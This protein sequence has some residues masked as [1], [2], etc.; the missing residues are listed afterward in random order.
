MILSGVSHSIQLTT[1]FALINNF[2]EMI[3]SIRIDFCAKT[4]L[5]LSL[6]LI[7]SHLLN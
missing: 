7:Y 1:G 3:I 6:K 5:E 4:L 2:Y